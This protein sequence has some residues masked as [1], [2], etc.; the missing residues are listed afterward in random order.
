MIAASMAF[1]TLAVTEYGDFNFNSMCLNGNGIPLGFSESG[2]FVLEKPA[3][4]SYPV[5]SEVTF[6]MTDFGSHHL[7]RIRYVN[8]AGVFG[9]NILVEVSHKTATA[10]KTVTITSLN[11]YAF[12]KVMIPR[13]AP[14]SKLAVRIASVSG[15]SI[16][17]NAVTLH[18][19]VVNRVDRS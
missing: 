17:I 3:S 7:K 4:L 12:L 1:D 15:A 2:M 18:L 8:I 13:I 16:V 14:S 11:Q 19:V 6:P 9:G 10:S 5:N